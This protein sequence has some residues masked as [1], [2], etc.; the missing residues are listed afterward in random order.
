M[1]HGVVP[2]YWPVPMR[3]LAIPL[4]ACT[5]A[6]SALVVPSWVRADPVVVVHLSSAAAGVTVT[7]TDHSGATHSCSTDD[8]GSCEIS[9]VVAGRAS[10]VAQQGSG[11]P[12][13]SASVLIPPDGKVSLIVPSPG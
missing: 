1:R 11:A 9:G 7:L 4:L 5:L 12:S 2:L 3:R 8:T 10:V 6:L 13:A